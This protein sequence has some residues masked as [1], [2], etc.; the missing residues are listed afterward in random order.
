MQK[1]SRWHVAHKAGLYLGLMSGTSADA[2]DA[3]LLHISPDG[4]QQHGFLSEPLPQDI[5]HE[6]AA[7][8]QTGNDEIERLSELHNKLGDLFASAALSLLEN[9]KV[10]PSEIVAIGSHGQTIRHRPDKLFTLQIGNPHLIA[11]RTGITTIAE[12]RQRDMALGG[13]G[14]PLVPRF[15]QEVFSHPSEYRVILNLGG[16]AN[17]TLLQGQELVGGFDTGPA[18]TLLDQWFQKHHPSAFF[19]RDG[20]WA[21]KGRV[22]PALLARLMNEPYLSVPPPKSTGR[23]LFNRVWLGSRLDGTEA[24]IDVQA[25]LTE[26]TAASLG[27]A[28]APLQPDRILVCGGGA[29]NGY[30]LERLQST[31]P[32]VPVCDTAS[33]GLAAEVVEAAAFAW[34]AWAHL[35]Q[36]PG[37]A[38]QVTGARQPAILGACFPA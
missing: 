32:R 22:L 18:N 6:I 10:T 38:P 8:C 30:L 27:E 2:I 15:H 16:I 36:I 7:L 33:A 35:N 14:A 13:Q 24:P 1:L 21:R 34:L 17:I 28:I 19:D 12:F 31:L 23:E 9:N 11:Q 29:Y 37:N 26:F 3:A 25:T 5:K 20:S 4:V